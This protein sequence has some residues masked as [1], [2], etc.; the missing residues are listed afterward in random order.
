MT[1]PRYTGPCHR[2]PGTVS[3][4]SL[5][6]YRAGAL[7]R[8]HPGSGVREWQHVG[9]VCRTAGFRGDELRGHADAGRISASQ[10]AGSSPGRNGRA[11]RRSRRRTTPL[12]PASRPLILAVDPP[13]ARGFADSWR[14]QPSNPRVASGL[15]I[16][17]RAGSPAPAGHLVVFTALGCDGVWR[18][19]LS[20]AR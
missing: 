3:P 15:K 1:T 5:D 7:R 9:T 10:R 14:A 12:L 18:R 16:G 13:E 20:T 4:P 11:P 19:W 6:V 17:A 2:W 8:G